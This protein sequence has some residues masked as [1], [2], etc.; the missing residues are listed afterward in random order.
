[1]LHY[2]HGSL[3]YN[4]R[5][6]KE[7]RCPSTDEWIK[8]MWYI[9]TAQVFLR[10]LYNTITETRRKVN[11]H[12]TLAWSYRK[13]HLYSPTCRFIG[14]PV[15][16]FFLKLTFIQRY[17]IFQIAILLKSSPPHVRSTKTSMQKIIIYFLDPLCSTIFE[18][19]KLPYCNI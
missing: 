8:K 12:L 19:E 4:S 16:C 17:L 9:Y 14:W 10:V 15:S 11:P 2:L 7:P 6:C 5:S 18:K 3:I 1:M 13:V